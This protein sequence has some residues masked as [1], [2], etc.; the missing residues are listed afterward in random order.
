MNGLFLTINKGVTN[1][2]KITLWKKYFY[3][4]VDKLL[5]FYFF[6]IVKSYSGHSRD[7]A[8]YLLSLLLNGIMLRA[9]TQLGISACTWSQLLR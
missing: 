2:N 6:F 5:A 9:R 7:M 4:I 1:L 3:I 8:F